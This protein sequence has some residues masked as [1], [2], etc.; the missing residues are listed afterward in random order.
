VVDDDP[1]AVAPIA[2]RILGV[3]STMLRAYGGRDAVDV[4]RQELPD[5]FGLHLMMPDVNGFD[6]VTA[7]HIT[8]EDRAKLGRHVTIMQKAG[9]DPD[10]FPAEARCAMSRRQVAA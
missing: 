7:R 10:S 3:A 2:V 6:V 5:L 9:F 8:A 1:K 4:A